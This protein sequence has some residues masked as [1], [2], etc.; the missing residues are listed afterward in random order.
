VSSGTIICLEVGR[1]KVFASALDW[2][3]WCRSG[4]SEE[5]AM[6]ALAEYA[7]RFAPVAERAGKGLPP[8]AGDSFEVVER[9]PGDGTTDFGAPHKIAALELDAI[10]AR[11]AKLLAAFVTAAWDTLADVVA[12]APAEMRKG[13]R[14]GGRD[15]D[16]IVE[17]VTLA[18]MAYARKLGIR[19]KDPGDVRKAIAEALAI[20][21]D[22]Q[23]PPHGWPTRYV[24]RRLAWHVLDHAWEIE[25][26][27]MGTFTL[28]NM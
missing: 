21:N 10:D 28:Q 6:E 24:S 11:S 27:S 23:V 17:H 3:G 20:P 14:G 25:D 12:V 18:E 4:K 5:L 8:G 13:P 22:G 16:K 1:K 15:R 7:P 26:K 2:P 9:I 19:S